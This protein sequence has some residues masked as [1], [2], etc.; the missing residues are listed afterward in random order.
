MR[1]CPTCGAPYDKAPSIEA[2]G[3]VLNRAAMTAE[4]RGHRVKLTSQ[5]FWVLWKIVERRGL[6]APHEWLSEETRGDP[7]N[8]IKMRVYKIRQALGDQAAIESVW[9]IGYKVHV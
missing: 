4:Y 5:E 7:R 1:C 9:G 8:A 3:I 2:G 6:T